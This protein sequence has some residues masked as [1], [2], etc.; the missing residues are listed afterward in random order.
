MAEAPR[1]RTP[2]IV[3][4]KHRTLEFRVLDVLWTQGPG[5]MREIRDRL[6][7]PYRPSYETVRMIV[8]RLQGRRAIRRLKKISNS[9]IFEAVITREEVQG[10]LI[11]DFASLFDPDIR[12]VIDRLVSTGRLTL[13]DLRDAER[14]LGLDQKRA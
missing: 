3:I 11:D 14:F 2:P 8:Y 12:P 1:G 6:P 9:Q 4:P 5:S 13:D 7:E 10:R